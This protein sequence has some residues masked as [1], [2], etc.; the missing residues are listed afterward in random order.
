LSKNRLNSP[1]TVA[2]DSAPISGRMNSTIPKPIVS[3][4]VNPHKPAHLA[5][6]P[7]WNAVATSTIP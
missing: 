3:N 1:N 6:S 5:V 2:N 4:S 7:R